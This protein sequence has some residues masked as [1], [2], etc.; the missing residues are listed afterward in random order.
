MKPIVLIWIATLGACIGSFTNVVWRLPRGESDVH[1]GSHCC[2][3]DHAIRWYDNIPLVSWL[4]LGDQCRDCKTS[5]S[6]KYPA[7]E[8]ITSLMWLS[9]LLVGPAGGGNLP[10]SWLPW[11]GLPLIACLVPLTMI[12]LDHLWLPEPLCRW[13]LILGL[14]ISCSGGLTLLSHHLIAAVLGLLALEGI[15]AW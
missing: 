5:V 2:R 9:S 12:D 1:P 3:C 8:V 4:V 14:L 13:G 7:V 10:S 15:S 6:W 11:A